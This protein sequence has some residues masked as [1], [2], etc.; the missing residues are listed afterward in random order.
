MRK[1]RLEYPG[2]WYHVIARGNQRQKGFLDAGDF[3]RYL[4]R[5]SEN[6][7]P[8]QFHLFAYCLMPNH[9]HLLLRQCSDL[10]LSRAMQRLQ[11]AYTAFFN[12]KHHK[13]GH[14]FQGRYKAI[15]VDADSY[16]KELVRYIHLNPWRAHLEESLGKYP[17]TS[18]A[19]YQGKEHDPIAPVQAR[20]VLKSF[21]PLK[22]MARKLYQ[23]HLIQGLSQGHREDLYEL[24]DG[25]ILGDEDFE[26]EIYHEAMVDQQARLKF[27]KSLAELWKCLQTRE[28]LAQE[29]EGWA[30]SRLMSEAAYW[31]VEGGGNTQKE[32]A[33][34]FGVDAS[35]ITCAL[36]RQG[37][38]WKTT[39]ALRDKSEKWVRSL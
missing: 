36:K 27:T 16:M 9:V 34:F 32:V 28:G 26:E 15:L 8:P 3:V 23:K 31:A 39:P 10:P 1:P 13:V 17:W 20:A 24:R 19:Q 11:G 6:F 5:L 14:L 25:R 2:A 35:T 37:N 33:D 30:R 7:R 38:S 22:R 4:T 21:S 12:H 29:P 18:H